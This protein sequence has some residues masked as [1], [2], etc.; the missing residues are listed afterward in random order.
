MYCFGGVEMRQTVAGVDTVKAAS[1]DLYSSCV[2]YIVSL[3]QHLSYVR[4]YCDHGRLVK[5]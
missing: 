1:K 5:L 2:A 4:N 3:H